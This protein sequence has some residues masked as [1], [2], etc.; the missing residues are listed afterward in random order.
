MI[1]TVNVSTELGYLEMKEDTLIDINDMD[2]YPSNQ[3]VILTTGSQ[4][5]EPM[6][7]LTRM[8][9]S[10]HRKIELVPEDLVVISASPP[11]PGNEKKLFLGLSTN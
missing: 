2:K 9:F 6:S 5:G 7:A 11:I 8:A 10:E 4:G 3:I 1:N